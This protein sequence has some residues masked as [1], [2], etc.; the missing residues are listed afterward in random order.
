MPSRIA[1]PAA[2]IGLGTLFLC[3]LAGLAI[4]LVWRDYQGAIERGEARAL[5]SAHIVAA[6]FQWM[7]QASDQALR[8]IDS[9]LG[10]EPIRQTTNTIVNIED[11]IGDL[12]RGFQ[13]SVYDEKGQLRFSSVKE[14][15][16]IN[17]SDRGYFKE[18]RDG[19]DTV[20]SP[21]LDERLSN[22]SVF[23]VARRITRSGE[24]H[25]AAS[26]AIPAARMAE[27]WASMNLGPFSTVSV[28][29]TDGWLIARFPP[30]DTSMDLSGTP[31][32]SAAGAQSGVYH[33]EVSPADGRAR[34]VGF[35]Q[36][37]G[38]PVIA[39]AGIERGEVLA[40]FWRNLLTGTTIAVPLFMMLGWGILGTARLQRADQARR[41]DLEQSLE[42]NKFLLREIHHRI[43]NN[44]QTVASLVRLQP[45]PLDARKSIAGR[46]GAMVAVHEH[47][48][49]NDEYGDVSVV[50]Y[51][52]RLIDDIKEAYSNDIEVLLKIEP[53]LV[54]RDQ[55]LPL[56]L[57][58]NEI[59]SNAFKHAFE[60]AT[61]GL[62]S[63]SLSKVGDR[64][65]RLTI[66]DN[67]RGFDPVNSPTNMGSKLVAAFASQLDGEITTKSSEGGTTVTLV[68]PV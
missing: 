55:A 23:V 1:A 30:I 34:I 39:A 6:H 57:L 56:G 10:P 18:L 59:L 38:M 12:P 19:S 58:V 35:R 13:Y 24:F 49:Q 51:L 62:I 5:S 60:G 54:K 61:S 41:R 64:E 29:R 2:T 47:I 15:V 9:V 22:I 25:G 42:H 17:V 37:E 27:F 45:L 31:L 3:A 53:L 16:G 8:R 40:S 4:L 36:I 65:A 67:G 7:F 33:S 11:A 48:Y 66:S 43:K 52:H 26:I 68:F 32:F 46:I 50:D 28:I 44:L 14:A 21:L 63:I 20:I